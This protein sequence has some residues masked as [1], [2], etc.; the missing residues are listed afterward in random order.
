M[1]QNEIVL[2]I[3]KNVYDSIPIFQAI[4]DR[5]R[6]F[7][8]LKL[9]YAGPKGVNVKDLS[10]KSWL[11]RPAI[12]HH[13]KI[14]KDAKII[15]SRKEGTQVYYYFNAAEKLVYAKQLTELLQKHT[16]ELNIDE[17]QSSAE[18]LND[19]ITKAVEIIK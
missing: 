9:V 12:S 19:I 15:E 5:E 16:T 18:G 10:Y 8:L 11:S 2:E 3:F 17:I 7:I 14:L 4:G 6:L 13:L 1:N